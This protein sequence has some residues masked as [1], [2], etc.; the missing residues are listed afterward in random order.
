MRIVLGILRWLGIAFGV[1]VAV[2]AA[3]F[4]LIQTPPGKA[5][6]AE[7]VAGAI[8]DPESR[9]AIEGLRGLVPFDMAA[10]RISFADRDGVYLTLRDVRVELSAAGLLAGRAHFPA[11]TIAEAEMSRRSTSP[12][13]TDYLSVPQLPA[14][15]V[16]DRIAIDRLAL[17]PA[18][19]GE[20][21]VAAAQ[22]R[23]VLAGG[24]EQVS[25]DLHRIDG[26]AGKLGLDLEI[27][28]AAEPV[29]T[30]DL[31]A[32]EPSGLLVD[33]ALGRADRLPFTLSLKGTGPL[34]DWHGRL[35]A[36]A[37]PDARVEAE[38]DI[39]QKTATAA[40]FKGEAALLP[41]LP[42]AYAAIVGDK[43]MF[44]VHATFGDKI[45][46]DHFA[47]TAAGGAVSGDAAV[48]GSDIAANL[49]GEIANLARFQ[50]LLGERIEGSAELDATVRGTRDRPEIE[51]RFSAERVR[52]QGS[53]IGHITAKIAAK[54]EAGGKVALSGS[55]RVEGLATAGV[56]LPPALGHDI[57]WSFA[58]VAA[59]DLGNAEL[60]RLSIKGAGL[61]VSASGQMTDSGRTVTGRAE[62][63]IADLRPFSGLAG[64]P[65]GGAT[66]LTIVAERRGDAGFE[67][68]IK[69]SGTGVETG[70]AAAD[71]LLGGSVALDGALERDAAGVLS[72]DRL[73]LTA[74]HLS[75]AATGKFDPAA[76]RLDAAG[77]IDLPRLA[78]LGPTLGVELAGALSAKFEAQGPLDHLR[79]GAGIDGRDLVAAGARID[80]LR[81]DA[82]V[83]DLAAQKLSAEGKFAASGID[84]AVTLAAERSGSELV[85]S[86]VRLAAAGAAIE[87]S[88]RVGLDTGLVSGSLAGRIP[89]LARW[90]ATG[91]D[92]ACGG[93][94]DAGRARCARWR[95]DART[96][97]ERA[98]DGGRRRI[99]AAFDR[100]VQSQRQPRRSAAQADR[101]G[102]VIA[103]RNL[104]RFNRSEEREPDLH[105]PRTRPPW[106]P[107]RGQRQALDDRFR[108][109]GRGREWRR[110]SAPRPFRRRPRRHAIPPRTT[111]AGDAAGE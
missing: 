65:I 104:R 48:S 6:L 11:L 3:G 28:G 43:L 18:V 9:V 64:R 60:T 77:D 4:G 88:L 69:G 8:S 49:H 27:A 101:I 31:E 58:A 109:R 13:S 71:A 34:A 54:P 39:A 12:G 91:A 79:L 50:G 90:S 17:G 105:E 38:L 99:I 14:P 111:V 75:V 70:I 29:L 25:L 94:R 87:G 42:P 15:V 19:L 53:G 20:P 7:R 51:A 83:P 78:P 59:R 62:I 1:I 56:P 47:L 86:Q 85:V 80:R 16:F 81:V 44:A 22:G 5:W 76:D 63:A 41:L 93:G 100:P 103:R 2:L 23:L 89:D 102:P 40:E 36:A 82:Q 68:T 106:L 10:E 45:V 97:G 110:R 26:K 35:A 72:F 30:L 37:G 96:D 98:Q 32:Q 92:A 46:V 73:K 66:R 67:A 57:D 108:R 21:V 61:D 55:G 74:D 107:R 52:L 24:K 95:P 84:G 33:R